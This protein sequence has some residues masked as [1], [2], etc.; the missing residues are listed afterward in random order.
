ML[1][2]FKCQGL[3]L[4]NFRPKYNN[5]GTQIDSDRTESDS[6]GL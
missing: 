6:S 5:D 2:W 4:D 1:N 3:I